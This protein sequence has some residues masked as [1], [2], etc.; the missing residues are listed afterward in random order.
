MSTTSA[1]FQLCHEFKNSWEVIMYSS[2]K[3][4]KDQLEDEWELL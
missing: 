2:L 3:K 4:K 1:L